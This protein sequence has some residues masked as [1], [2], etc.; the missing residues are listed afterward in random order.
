VA[1]RSGRLRAADGQ[2]WPAEGWG[3][4]DLSGHGMTA[5]R[6]DRTTADGRWPAT[7]TKSG[8]E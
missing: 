3:R 7:P 2:I 5:V 6:D 8:G 4:L 1:A